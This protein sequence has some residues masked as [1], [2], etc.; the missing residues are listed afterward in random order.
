MREKYSYYEYEIS[1]YQ[2][3]Y[4]EYK[5]YFYD[6]Y[7]YREDNFESDEFYDTQSEARNSVIEHIDRLENG[8]H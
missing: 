7:W 3:I 1:K 4:Y 6:D 8:G 5:I 2:D